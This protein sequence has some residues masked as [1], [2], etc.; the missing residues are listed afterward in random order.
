MFKNEIEVARDSGTVV[1]DIWSVRLEWDSAFT[2][3]N[4]SLTKYYR[5]MQFESSTLSPEVIHSCQSRA[6]GK[7]LG[8]I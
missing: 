7:N 1:A 4:W 5:V 6:R 2:V 8:I 3:Y